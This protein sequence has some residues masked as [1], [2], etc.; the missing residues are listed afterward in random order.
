[1]NRVYPYIGIFVGSGLITV[2]LFTEPTVGTMLN[3]NEY[4]VG[5]HVNHRGW[6]E[7]WAKPLNQRMR[8]RHV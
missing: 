7:H 3:S 1:M 8:Y 4:T 5:S 6:V 2:V